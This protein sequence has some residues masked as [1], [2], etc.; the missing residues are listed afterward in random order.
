MFL[1]HDTLTQ[2]VW[3]DASIK[4]TSRGWT[5]WGTFWNS[6]VTFTISFVEVYRG[7]P[8]TL[9]TWDLE[10]QVYCEDRGRV[11]TFT[12]HLSDA[13]GQFYPTLHMNGGNVRGSFQQC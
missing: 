3:A 4:I 5:T 9:D 6:K 2:K 1:Y 8:R 13:V 7:R 12:R 11:V 10:Y